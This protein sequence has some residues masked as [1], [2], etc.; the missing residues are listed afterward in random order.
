[1]RDRRRDHRQEFT[2]FPVINHLSPKYGVSVASIYLDCSRHSAQFRLT[3]E[4]GCGFC[5]A[6]GEYERTTTNCVDRGRRA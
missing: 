1:V 4:A 5:P 3:K 2:L 6:I